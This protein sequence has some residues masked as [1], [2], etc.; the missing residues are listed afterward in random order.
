MSFYVLQIMSS[1]GEILYSNYAYLPNG[2]ATACPYRRLYKIPFITLG[3]CLLIA[4]MLH[5]LI[6]TA[7]RLPMVCTTK[8]ILASRNFALT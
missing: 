2:I 3:F 4:P 5:S 6:S 1:A 8:L 7:R